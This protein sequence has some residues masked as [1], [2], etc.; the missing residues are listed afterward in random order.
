MHTRK[1]G[2]ADRRPTWAVHD[3]QIDISCD[4]AV[5]RKNSVMN[6]APGSATVVSVN[7]GLPRAARWMGRTVTSSIWKTPVDGP[8]GIDGVNLV[9]DDQAD[10]RVHGGVHKAVYAYSVEDYDWWATTKGPSAPGTFG[11]NLTTVGIDLS[12]SHIGDQWHVG[13]AVLEIA[14]PRQPCFKLGM[15]MN[16]VGFPGVFAAARRPGAYLRILTAGAVQAGDMIE[17]VAARPPAVRIDWLV[18]DEIDEEVLQ[19]VATDSRVPEG[20]RDFATR[21]L[22]R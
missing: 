21:A 2:N 16:D 17:I 4:Q 1:L 18:D 19:L 20:W 5:A 6:E 13:T 3:D 11:E 7:V 15:R 9:G 22:S 14:Q 8:V 10:R 12:T